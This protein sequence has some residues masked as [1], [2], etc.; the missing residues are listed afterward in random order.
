MP[1][2][3]FRCSN[4]GKEF[5]AVE[6]SPVKNEDGSYADVTTTCSCGKTATR[7]FGTCAKWLTTIVPSSPNCKKHKAGY[8]HTHA[9]R[10]ATKVMGK[11][12]S[13]NN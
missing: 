3:D 8:Q 5:E 1:M 10:P 9:D 12:W 4:C 2:Y 7:T 11:G 6:K 13:P